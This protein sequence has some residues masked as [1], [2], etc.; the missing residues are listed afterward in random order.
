MKPNLFRIVCLALLAAG[1]LFFAARP[2]FCAEAILL[3]ISL[4]ITGKSSHAISRTLERAAQ[5]IR[6]AESRD[7]ANVEKPTLDAPET[8][9]EDADGF[10]ATPTV[11]LQFK[12]AP[13]QEAFGRGSSFGA[14]YELASLLIGEKFAGIRTVAYFP[15]SVKG[16][17]LLVALACSERIIAEGAEIG[18]A[19]IDEEELS[20][21][22]REAYMEIAR[23]RPS[24]P[25]AVVEKIFDPKVTLLQLE[26]EKGLRLVTP[27]EVEELRKTE[28]FADEPEPLL[29]AGSPGLFSAETARRINLA[30]L[31]AND[32]V[33]LA[34][35]L[36][37]RPD[38][39]KNAPIPGELGHAVRINIEGL[40][41]PDNTGAAIRGINTALEADAPGGKRAAGTSQVDFLCIYINSPGGDIE[42][43]LNL[44]SYIL[45][46]VDANQVRTVAYV[47]FQALSDAALIALAC[48]EIVLGPEAKLGGDGAV[49]FS[50][51]R[52][53]DARKTLKGFLSKA[54]LRSW[55][56]PVGFIDRDIE[57]FEMTRPGRPP[58]VDYFCD[59]ELAEQPDAEL[60]KKGKTVKEKGKFLEIIGGKGNQFF[61]DRVAADFA[62]F[63]FLYGIENDPHLVEPSW[64]DRVVRVLASPGMGALILMIVFFAVMIESNTPG[65]GIGA[66]VAVLGIVFFFWINFLGGTAGWLEVMLFLVGVLCICLEIFVLPGMGI[67]GLGGAA[68]IIISLVLASQTFIIPQNSYQLGQFRNSILVLAVSGV[69]VFILGGA[70][71]RAIHNANRPKDTETIKELEKL[72]SYDHL[73][74][75]FGT[76]ST[77]LVPA[78]KAVF[79]GEP[80]DV[81]SDGG[82]IEKGARIEV[83]EV[84][85]YRVV[86]REA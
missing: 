44:A 37:F 35:G 40:I 66:F 77:P 4:P 23:R 30:N 78:G 81:V 25:S 55:S 29:P 28:T 9:A 34:R 7:G 8:T 21:T 65:L 32:R 27:D 19:T 22:E 75:E 3:D 58:L 46:N 41:T 11:I 63:K 36:G 64:A 16:H 83:V 60:W 82:L 6:L 76:A 39:I 71:S 80:I 68:A 86:V 73:V 61:V 12:V 33:A 72:A 20:K 57:V 43:S 26:T 18:E 48:D 56:L 50:A 84:I 67:F 1:I 69:G 10:R 53:E 51:Q 79:G 85:G 5:E 59:E 24:L 54:A 38:D 74:G 45:E 14:C 13:D 49:E 52:L 31:I 2:A 70:I 42:S 15:Q 47:P 62:E 17:A